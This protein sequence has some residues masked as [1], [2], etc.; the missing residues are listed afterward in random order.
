MKSSLPGN[1]LIVISAEITGKCF[2]SAF[3][4]FRNF[5]S[6]INSALICSK[7][8]SERSVQSKLHMS[9]NFKTSHV[10]FICS[11]HLLVN[12]GPA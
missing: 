11:Q 6:E 7:S 10:N 3:D 12:Y 4:D 8:E 2:V 9:L 5:D 1:V